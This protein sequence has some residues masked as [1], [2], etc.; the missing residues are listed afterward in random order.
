MPPKIL[1]DLPQ[2]FCSQKRQI[3]DHFFRDFRTRHRISPERNVASTNKMLVSIYNVFPTSWPTFRDLWPRN[4]WDPFSYCD[5]TFGGHYVAT[6]IKVATSLV[7]LLLLPP[8]VV[9]SIVMGVSLCRFVCLFVYHIVYIENRTSKF[10]RGR[11][12]VLLWWQ[13]HIK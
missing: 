10:T 11:D 3:L 4:G 8:V 5:P 1:G 7:N 6:I 9:R 13:R 12:S 2:K